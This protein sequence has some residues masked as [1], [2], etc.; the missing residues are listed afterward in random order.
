MLAVQHNRER[1]AA[2]GYRVEIPLP[3]RLDHVLRRL[4]RANHPATVMCRRIRLAVRIE[5]LYLESGIHLTFAIA[6]TQE[7]PRVPLLIELELQIKNEVAILTC[8]G[9]IRV[10]ALPAVLARPRMQ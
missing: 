3:R 9:Q 8:R 10:V 1:I 7:Y 4:H 2:T 5:N 6:N